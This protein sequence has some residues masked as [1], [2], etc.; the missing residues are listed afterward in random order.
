MNKKALKIV[1]GIIVVVVI[2]FF[3]V[4][5][6]QSSD[7]FTENELLTSTASVT[8]ESNDIIMSEA[9]FLQQMNQLR[10]V[11]LD[12]TAILS[13]PQLNAL[14]DNTVIIPD[15]KRGRIN[16]FEEITARAKLEFQNQLQT[17]NESNGSS[18][19]QPDSEN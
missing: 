9:F 2:G 10:E 6:L 12:D 5:L 4:L 14:N 1:I 11:T 15:F 3:M 13:S 16:P 8:T 18:T 19:A 17:T 7:D